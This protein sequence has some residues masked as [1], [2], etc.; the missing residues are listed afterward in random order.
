MAS[1]E[2]EAEA[3]ALAVIGNPETGFAPGQVATST[4]L[5]AELSVTDA[6]HQENQAA[7]SLRINHQYRSQFCVLQSFKERINQQGS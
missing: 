4:T 1:A 5:L 2:A 3:V 6:M 7:T